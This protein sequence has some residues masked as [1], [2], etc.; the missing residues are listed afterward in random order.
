M[1]SGS[2]LLNSPALKSLKRAQLVGLC[3]RYGL[4]AAGKNVELIQ[5]LQ[6]HGRSDALAS[7]GSYDISMEA[8]G[9]AAID[10]DTAAPRPSEAW[11][12]VDEPSDVEIENAL[13]GPLAVK[14]FGGGPSANKGA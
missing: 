1:S 7:V 5:R 10:K 2:I 8:D 4:R 14:E 9:G 11:S 13:K 12:I 3:K 6:E